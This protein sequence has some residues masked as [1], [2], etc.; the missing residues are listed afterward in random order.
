MKVRTADL[1]E[2]DCISVLKLADMW[3]FL[4]IRDLAIKELSN[5]TMDPF[6]KVLL[7]KRYKI[8]VWLRLG[9]QE[10]ANREEIITCEE[11][12][13]LG[14]DAAIRIFHL[15]DK[16]MARFVQGMMEEVRWHINENDINIAFAKELIDVTEI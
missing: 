5:R 6:T 2:E 1:S 13:Q 11:A 16:A 10:L 15:R 12:K 3:E 9:Y 4:E 14:W 8:P 7:A